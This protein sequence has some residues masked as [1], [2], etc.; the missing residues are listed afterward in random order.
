[1]APARIIRPIAL[2]VALLIGGVLVFTDPSGP[3]TPAVSAPAQRPLR[4]AFPAA[5]I[6][7]AP[8]RLADGTRYQP[9]LYLDATTSIGVAP[10]PDGTAQRVLLRTGGTVREVARAGQD[11]YPRFAA[12]TAAGD[13]VFWVESTATTTQPLQH[14]IFRLAWREDSAGVPL[15]ADTGDAEFTGGEYDLV[16]HDGL[17]S[18]AAVA[19]PATEIRSVPLDGGPVTTTSVDG[20]YEL[21]AWPWLQT[22][23]AARAAGR[24]ELRDLATGKRITI[25]KS[26]AETVDCGPSWCRSVV[27]SGT[28]GDTSLA[29]LHPDGTA[30]RRVGGVDT[31]PAAGPPALLDRFSAVLQ[32]GTRTAYD[33]SHRL[34]LYDLRTDRL[35]TVAD[36]ADQ[37]FARGH[38]LWWSRGDV[39][40]S[41]DLAT[42]R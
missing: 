27:S 2:G 39:W 36:D 11:R 22:G 8:A 21:S 24:Q 30:R 37:V 13:D 34:A 28:G 10:T 1:M 20:S 38:M 40:H 32:T 19:G 4:Q 6:A 16:A 25:V 17:L 26:A 7:D 5:T 35:I 12:F 18:W 29:L 23:A 31:F 9:G 41:L 15:A 42:L 14:R 3:S 33:S